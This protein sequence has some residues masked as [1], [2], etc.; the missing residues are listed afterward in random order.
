MY[1]SLNGSKL[2]LKLNKSPD[3][4]YKEYF[5]TKIDD[6]SIESKIQ[7]IVPEKA[8]WFLSQK[9]VSDIGSLRL[10]NGGIIDAHMAKFGILLSSS[11]NLEGDIEYLSKSKNIK[12]VEDIDYGC[13][14][15]DPIQFLGKFLVV[16]RGEC[17]LRSKA[18]W[19]QEAG[20]LA[21]LVVSD[22]ETFESMKQSSKLWDINLENG[23]DMTYIPCFYFTKSSSDILL[24][25]PS[26]NAVLNGPLDKSNLYYSETKISNL[27]IHA[28]RAMN[29]H[30]RKGFLYHGQSF[31]CMKKCMIYICC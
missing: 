4:T 25:S 29:T 24:K 16:R 26:S 23:N 27:I 12:S 22:K 11:S 10:S 1:S 13:E 14:P 28:E 2:Q 30:L 20:A 18:F 21:L 5:I 8:A 6:D 17:K 3:G 15:L 7:V 31:Q 9:V 19:A